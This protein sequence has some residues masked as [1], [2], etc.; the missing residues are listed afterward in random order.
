MSGS[1]ELGE[2]Q[3]ESMQSVTSTTIMSKMETP[4]IL[5]CSFFPYT[6]DENS[7][8]SILFRCK[9]S[10]SKQQGM[11]ADFGTTLKDNEPNILFSAARSYVAKTAGLCLDSELSNLSLPFE[12]KRILKESITKG[13]IEIYTNKKVKEVLKE[14]I[15]NKFTVHTEVIAQNHLTIFYPL[16]YFRTEPINIQ[17]FEEFDGTKY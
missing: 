5:S 10:D 16:A 11:Y 6:I 7:Q 4:R 14:I 9:K 1:Q 13:P 3:H 15:T 12:I 17:L 2:S 8:L